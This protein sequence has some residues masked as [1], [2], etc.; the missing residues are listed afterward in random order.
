VPERRKR[1]RAREPGAVASARE[2]LGVSADAPLPEVTRAYWR[3]ARRL[4]PDLSPDPEATR[5]FQALQAA[6]RLVLEETLHTPPPPTTTPHR[7]HQG[8]N[9]A[10]TRTTVGHGDPTVR[11]ASG[12]EWPEAGGSDGVWVVAGPVQVRPPGRPDTR[13]DPRDE[14]P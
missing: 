8:S 9:P 10:P 4:H 13:P 2:L 7:T 5:H 11:V 12:S 3:L 1:E 6:Y 14:R